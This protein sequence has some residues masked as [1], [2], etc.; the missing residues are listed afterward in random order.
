MGELREWAGEAPAGSRTLTCKDGLWATRL[1]VTVVVVLDAMPD[2]VR[3]FRGWLPGSGPLGG[4]LLLAA[5]A[6]LVPVGAGG[7]QGP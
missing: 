5:R 6:L 7:A 4:W 3:A 2:N 1:G